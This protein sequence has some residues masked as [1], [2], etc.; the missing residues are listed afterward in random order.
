MTKHK[1]VIRNAVIL[2]ICLLSVNAAAFKG[3]G[4]RSGDSL[5]KPGLAL[6][7]DNLS[8]GELVQTA[9]GRSP[10]QVRL[11]AMNE[12]SSALF[13]RAGNLLGSQPTLNI[14]GRSDQWQSDEGVREYQLGIGLPMRHFGERQAGREL[15]ERTA[16][17]VS[18]E[19]NDIRLQM[20][21][22]IRELIWDYALAEN[23]VESATSA[24]KMAKKTESDMTRRVKLGELSRSDLLLAQQQ[25]LLR[26]EKLSAAL[27]EREHTLMRYEVIAGSQRMPGRWRERF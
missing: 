16:E 7:N 14:T 13:K 24:L 9:L 17:W 11:E 22:T 18:A 25:T 26:E 19:W 4:K 8:L 15:A 5:P 23:A 12:R 1:V 3:E 2:M 21:G 10:D 27:A 20:S 6:R